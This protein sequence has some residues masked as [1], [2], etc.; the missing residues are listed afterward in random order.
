MAKTREEKLA[1]RKEYRDANKEKLAKEFKEWYDI[2]REGTYARAKKWKENNPDKCKITKWK[3][4]GII[5][6]DFD[7]LYEVYIKENNCWICGVYF[8]VSNH[9]CLDHDHDIKDDDNVRYICCR[10]C[11][12]H[13]IG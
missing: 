8:C 1:Q 7:L 6:G 11:N 13:I 12:I 10:N 3:L 2:N 9:R 5:D 4:N